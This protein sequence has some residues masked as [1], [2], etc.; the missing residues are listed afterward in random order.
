VSGKDNGILVL[1]AKGEKQ[2]DIEVGTRMDA[3]VT[4]IDAKRVIEQQMVPAF[5]K[6]DYYSGLTA[7]VDKLIATI[8]AHPL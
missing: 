7:A 2:I 1:V 3:S 4:D 8:T 5:S 6:K